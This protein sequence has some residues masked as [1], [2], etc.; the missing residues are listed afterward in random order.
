MQGARNGDSRCCRDWGWRE[1]YQYRLSPGQGRCEKAEPELVI[2]H[3]DLAAVDPA[4]QKK[5]G[6]IAVAAQPQPKL[7]P[8][9]DHHR[10]QRQ[11]Q[12]PKSNLA[13]PGR[14]GTL[15]FGG[16][17]SVFGLWLQRYPD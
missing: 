5:G 2:F 7:Q 16:R 4:L 14:F 15:N 10:D 3:K 17:T 11:R 9:K 8:P 13:P 6:R 1:W 12:H